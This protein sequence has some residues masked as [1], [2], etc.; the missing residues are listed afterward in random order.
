MDW[1][2][3]IGD[4]SGPLSIGWAKD[5]DEI[6]IKIRVPPG[7]QIDAPESIRI[8]VSDDSEIPVAA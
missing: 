6:I 7:A 5:G 3:L 1:S 8:V 2:F 4:Y